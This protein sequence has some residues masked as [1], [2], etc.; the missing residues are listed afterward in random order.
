MQGIT[1]RLGR[2]RP[3]GW[4][5]TP[6]EAQQHGIDSMLVEELRAE[7]ECPQ[8]RPTMPH[9]DPLRA[10]ELPPLPAELREGRLLVTAPNSYRYGPKDG[11][12]IVSTVEFGYED[13]GPV[14]ADLRRLTAS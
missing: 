2:K 6:E 10:R 3:A 1:Y 9:A 12:G 14:L 5:P 8:P 4:V 11:S 7:A 13:V